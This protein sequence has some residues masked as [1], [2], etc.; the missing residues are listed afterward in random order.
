[1]PVL[2]RLRPLRPPM[3]RMRHQRA[4]EVDGEQ[5]EGV[6]FWWEMESAEMKDPESMK[7]RRVPWVGV[8]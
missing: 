4:Y 7:G 5:R 3:Q 2:P 8:S 6:V 1:M